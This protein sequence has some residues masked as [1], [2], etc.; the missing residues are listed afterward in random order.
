MFYDELIQEINSAESFL[1]DAKDEGWTEEA[2]EFQKK[3]LDKLC[4]LKEMAQQIYYG[5]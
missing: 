4:E 3:Y 5:D 1:E 2:I